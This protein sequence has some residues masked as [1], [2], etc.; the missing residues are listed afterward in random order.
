MVSLRIGLDV[1]GTFTDLTGLATE[2]GQMFSLKIRSTPS[3]PSFAILEGLKKILELSKFTGSDVS[4]FGHGTT[5]VTNGIIERKGANLGIIT[6]FGFKDILELARQSRP[7]VYDYSKKRPL[8]IVPRRHRFEI[9]ERTSASGEIIVAPKISEIDTVAKKVLDSGLNA[10]AICFLHSYAN[11]QNELLVAKELTSRLPDI[12]I[13]TSHEIAAEYREYERF[14]TV[15]LNAFIGL[16]AGDYFNRTQDGIRKQGIKAPLYTITSNAGL[17]DIKTAIKTPIKTALSGPAA[18]V[19]GIGRMLGRHNLG[20][21]VTFDVGGTSTDIAILEKN[22]PRPVRTRLVSG[23]PV[24]APMI[25]IEVIGAGGGSLA[26]VDAGGALAVGPLSAGSEP[27]PAAFGKGGCIPTLTDAA[28]ILGR[29]DPIKPISGANILDYNA[30]SRAIEKFVA[31]P[32]NSK[33][34][35]AAQ[36]IVSIAAANMART[37]RSAAASR[38]VDTDK[39]TIVAYGGAGPLF[40]ADVADN[41]DI[42]QFVV[43]MEPGT[44]CARAM[45]VSD[46]A[47]DFSKTQIIDLEIGNWERLNAIFR[48]LE[49]SGQNWLQSEGVPIGK[50]KIEKIIEMRYRGQN[51]ELSIPLTSE[52][53]LTT[54]CKNFADIHLK[55]Q[56]YVLNSHPIQAVTLRLKAIAQISTSDSL[57]TDVDKPSRKGKF[58]RKVAWFY[59]KAYET[60]VHLR[61]SLV[62]NAILDGPAIIQ[63][64]TSTTVLP[65]SW[66]VRILGDGTMLANSKG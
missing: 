32:L 50:R 18:G 64:N 8:P 10:L 35:V 27:G 65:P 66:Q 54:L 43:P 52:E 30:A 46:L 40:A 44:L 6:T 36:G 33:V 56:G 37:I 49:A 53:N 58:D 45:L 5:V 12:F 55:E 2:S 38:G 41:L 9:R 48:E 21:L 14:S 24:L 20:D 15:A 23:F 51:F 26:S 13:S 11:P 39:L 31:T 63:E 47:K 34:E 62:A 7:H 29:I 61:E 25:D 3:D 28:I 60:K 22:K 1:G 42:T 4:F 57:L 59:G 16:K 17:I 19:S